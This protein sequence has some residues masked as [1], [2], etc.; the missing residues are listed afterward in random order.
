MPDRN[1]LIAFGSPSDYEK[2]FS[3]DFPRLDSTAYHLS[4]NSA[5][6]VPDVVGKHARA[7]HYDGV[8][9]GAGMKNALMDSYFGL[10]PDAIHVA[11]PITDS[12]TGGLSSILSSSEMP[13]GCPVAMS[14]MSDMNAAVGF[15]NYALSD[16]FRAVRL[17]RDNGADSEKVFDDAIRTFE[18]LGIEVIQDHSRPAID[19][20]AYSGPDIL[21]ELNEG[22][23][24]ASFAS[25]F[26]SPIILD[27]YLRSLKAN[28]HTVHTGVAD[29][30][31]LAL[32]A[33]KIIARNSPAVREKID[34]RFR[35]G[36]E[37]YK[38]FEEL[39]PL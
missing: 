22:F 13:P 29:G 32:Y 37:K 25:P 33:A 31:N 10:C 35:A 26:R 23:V 21:E 2:F 39:R 12:R 11:L 18:E 17:N 24:I 4:V 16:I 9:A 28:A 1:V 5:H 19:V 3:A 20:V 36:L 30:S 27:N 38:P 6:R 14:R 8:I 34:E 7:M 15:V